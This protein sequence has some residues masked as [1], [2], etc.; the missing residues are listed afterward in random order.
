MLQPPL[1]PVLKVE[2][3]DI[4]YTTRAGP[5]QAVRDVS[6][7]IRPGDALGVVGESGCGKSTLAFGVMNYIAKNGQITRGRILF[8]SE[9]MLQKSQNELNQI[10]GDK[11]A[12]V[13]Q[14]PMAALN[15]SMRIGNQLTE[16]L[17]EH[18]GLK[19]GPAKERCLEMLKRV[20]MPDP[21]DIMDRYPHQLSG[22]QQQRVLI[23]MALLLDPELLI[24]DEPTTGLD[25]TIEAGILDLISEL[26]RELGATI[27][28]ISHN[29]GVISQIA[30]R[31]AVMYAGEIV[32]EGLVQD[33]FL[34]PQHPYTV[35]LLACIPKIEVSRHAES[36]R[37]IRGRVPTLIGELQGCAFKPRCDRVDQLCQANY[38]ELVEVSD[39]HLVR[40]LYLDHLDAEVVAPAQIQHGD[41]TVTP[42]EDDLVLGIDHLKTYYRAQAAGLAGLAGREKKAFVKAVDDV[43]LALYRRNTFGI[44]GESGCGKTTLAKCVA[45]LVPSNSGEMELLGIDI[46]QVVE[47]RSEELLPELQMIFQNPDSTLNPMISV[48]DAIARPLRLFA[49][50][51]ANKIRDEVIRL[52]EAVRLGVEYYDRLPRQLSGGEKQRVAIARAFA[53]RPSLVLCDEP[54]SALDVSV[55]VAVMNLLLEFQ[56]GYGSTMLFISHDLS[57]VYQLCDQVAVMY[58]GQFC[59]VGPTEDLYSPPYHPYTEAL[60]SAI[61]IPDPTLERTRIRLTGAVPSA[62]DPPSGCKFHTRCPRKIGPVCEQESPPQRE[63][64]EGHHIFC[65]I[66]QEALRAMEPVIRTSELTEADR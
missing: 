45:G 66:D 23:A 56:Q 35:A 48:G 13:Y 25:V 46:R 63:M 34:D 44:V 7:E 38:P 19:G 11:I 39:G 30:D 15:P 31:M 14:D 62:L 24:M 10:R 12:M 16:V 50:V 60:L 26:K 21:A 4:I 41:A 27:L 61:P 17:S 1:T 55:Q 33:I 49:T 58:L 36:L 3:L 28:Y 5:V 8:S 51:P 59:E 64:A 53:G 29:L 2:D 20:R 22:G 42:I 18:E 54:L 37:P 9:D 43:N 40:C 52:L 6:F 65:H 32:E 47:Q 57:V